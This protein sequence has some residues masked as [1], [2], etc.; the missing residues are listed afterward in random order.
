MIKMKNVLCWLG[1]VGAVLFVSACTA[2]QTPGPS[3]SS[4]CATC[5]SYSHLQ[6]TVGTAN[7]YGTMSGLNVV[8]T[9]R[10]PNGLSALGV[11][12]PTLTGPFVIT[13]GAASANN[14]LSDPYSTYPDGGPSLAE[15]GADPGVIGGTPQSVQ[16]GT[17]ACDTTLAI[18]GFITCPA[19]Q[20]PNAS[21]LGE[22]G[23]VFAMGLAPYNVEAETSLSYS[24][25]PYAQPF[26]DSSG[27]F[28]LIP[29]GG[30]PAF[31][32]DHNGM[33]TRD[34]LVPLGSD[35]FGLNYFLGVGEGVTAF[36]NVTPSTGS[37]TL[38]VQIGEA[39][40]NG[41][42]YKTIS[43]S[44][45]LVSTAPLGTA[46]APV[47]T[48]D[49]NGDGGASLNVTLPAGATEALVQV[50]DWG[51]G[52]GP[53]NGG[54]LVA[55]CHGPKGEQFAPVYYTVEVT[56]S[57]VVDLPT[58]DGPNTN[59]NGGKDNLT[60]SPTICT[61]AD[62]NNPPDGISAP[63]PP[64]GDNFTVQLIGFDYPAYEAAV[65]LLGAH[66]PQVPA[67]AGPGGQSDITISVPVEEDYPNYNVQIPLAHFRK[68]VKPHHL[69]I[70]TRKRAAAL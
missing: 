35:S 51:P 9:L 64:A 60:P 34:G 7:L 15:S 53:N 11:D 17:P 59:L 32:P 45:S 52:G 23:G 31:D 13:A 36:E 1:V 46:V 62:N 58:S 38:A 37:Y 16:I 67:I 41:P 28:P 18:S 55:N 54:A 44:A 12:T 19:G 66:P 30:P 21:T 68:L 40:P 65:G 29:W 26:Y 20:S 49:A 6:V 4:V 33:G 25:Q 8:S 48:P 10:Q 69:R 22:S 50:V 3:I 24:Y 57:G 61:L 27:H 43:A 14:S 2:G 47:V 5:P 70:V 42:T 56:S 63:I 39:G